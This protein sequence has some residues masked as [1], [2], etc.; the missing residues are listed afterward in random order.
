M[1]TFLNPK[2]IVV[3]ANSEKELPAFGRLWLVEFATAAIGITWNDNNEFSTFKTGLCFQ[4]E[5]GENFDKLRFKNTSGADVTVS[6]LI[7]NGQIFDYRKEFSLDAATITALAAALN[8]S[9]ELKLKI[10]TLAPGAGA[11]VLSG[12]KSIEVI[13]AGAGGDFVNIATP[14]GTNFDLA[15]GVGKAFSCETDNNHIENVTITPSASCGA[16][17]TALYL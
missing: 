17:I 14:S 11:L 9:V 2:T 5:P 13:A 7:G 4:L 6:L 16:E 10:V 15:S 1:K 3:K 8:A 12:C